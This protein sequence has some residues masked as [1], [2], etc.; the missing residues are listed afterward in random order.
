MGGDEELNEGVLSLVRVIVLPELL[1]TIY[2]VLFATVLSTFFGFILAIILIITDKTGLRPN[3]LVYDVLDV[4]INIIRS[5]PFIILIVAMLPLTRLIIGTSIGVHAAIVPLTIAASPFIAR[6]VEGSLKEVDKNLIEAARSFGASDIQIIFRIMIK[7]AV[8]S[9]ISV[10][11]VA[12]INIL[13]ATAMAGAV[14][15]GG[16]GAVALAYGYQSFNETVMYTTVF[17]LI[18][19]VQMIQM[20]G[21]YVYRR[22]KR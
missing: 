15:A 17:V 7:E 10:I 11:T 5:F 19:I 4:G 18:I 16:L 21:N 12:V 6:L 9:L 8:P 3:K 1:F 14:G 13:G 20:A 22:S 2:M